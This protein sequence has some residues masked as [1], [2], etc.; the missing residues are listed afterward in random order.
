MEW[1]PLARSASYARMTKDLYEHTVVASERVTLSFVWVRYST[2]PYY[3]QISVI[4]VLKTLTSLNLLYS[5]FW[6]HD[7]SMRL[8]VNSRKFAIFKGLPK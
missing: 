3:Y 1:R 7:L 8:S 2:L 6:Q 4:S 5:L